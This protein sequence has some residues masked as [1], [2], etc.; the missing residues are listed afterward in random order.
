M[1]Q[2]RGK[3][4]RRVRSTSGP[5]NRRAILRRR[6]RTHQ[7]YLRQ[8]NCQGLKTDA[9][10]RELAFS[11]NASRAFCC[12][13]QETWRTGQ[14]FFTIDGVNFILSGPKVQIG[15][16]T[17]GIGFALSNEAFKLWEQS[18][19]VKFS[20]ADERTMGIRIQTKD[21]RGRAVGLFLVC[22]YAP[23][24]TAPD[25][26]WDQFLSG[27]DLVRKSAKAGDIV[28]TGGD[29]NSSLGTNAQC[30]AAALDS[31]MTRSRAVDTSGG[32]GPFGNTHCNEAGR[33]LH[34]HISSEGI[35][36]CSTYFTKKQYS[37]WT[38]PCSRLGHQIDHFFID[39][40]HFRRVRDCGYCSQL[41]G[42]DHGGL[43]LRL[44]FERRM[45]KRVTRPAISTVDHNSLAGTL[46]ETVELRAKFC[47]EVTKQMSLLNKADLF[48]HLPYS[49]IA[50]LSKAEQLAE[51]LD[52]ASHVMPKKGKKS[53]QWFEASASELKQAIELR[54]TAV[55][56]L[57][58]K[59]NCPVVQRSAQQRRKELKNKIADAKSRWIASFCTQVNTSNGKAVWDAVCELKAALAG[60]VPPRPQVRMKKEGGGHC[61]TPQ[62]NAEVFS[63]FFSGAVWA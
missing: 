21:S 9:Q 1:C 3:R 12:S 28:V 45:E 6:S 37:T 53:P 48:S 31:M 54:N 35:V 36:A 34:S 2:G 11:F 29:F 63:S 19:S 33:R 5:R 58:S 23:V 49:E 41:V 22:C 39:K 38:H 15:R 20:S 30:D 51:A 32:V 8:Q 16:G 62:E 55:R 52:R 13:L 24:G 4:A 25:S 46:E 40:S 61:V 50:P 18:G 59:P 60:K 17:K 26:E 42:S 27:W 44:Q 10:L 47:A 14:E 56:L 7:V 43:G 57:H